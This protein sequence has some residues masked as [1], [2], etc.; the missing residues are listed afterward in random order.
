MLSEQNRLVIYFSVNSSSFADSF[1]LEIKPSAAFSIS[2][3]AAVST[4]VYSGVV[5]LTGSSF[6]SVSVPLGRREPKLPSSSSVTVSPDL[7]P[8]TTF[9]LTSSWPRT[10]MPGVE[11]SSRT[12][13]GGKQETSVYIRQI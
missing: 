6:T 5:K 9:G 1:A 2:S 12:S 11:S 7:V 4:A 13:S 3:R 8:L 10:I